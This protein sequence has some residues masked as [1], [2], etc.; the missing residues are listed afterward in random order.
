MT[1]CHS[2]EAYSFASKSS[3]Q[4]IIYFQKTRQAAY[5]LFFQK[6]VLT[7]Q[8][9]FVQ[10]LETPSRCHRD[11]VPGGNGGEESSPWG[12]SAPGPAGRALAGPTVVLATQEVP[13]ALACASPRGKVTQDTLLR[14]DFSI[15]S[16]QAN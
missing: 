7:V 2:R 9:R 1:D 15:I 10:T 13:M 8:N 14:L 16:Q 11:L 5:I 4:I 6:E 3:V 12:L